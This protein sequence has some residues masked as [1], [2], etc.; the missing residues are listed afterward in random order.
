MPDSQRAFALYSAIGNKQGCGG[1]ISDLIAMELNSLGIALRYLGANAQALA[2]FRESLTVTS[3]IGFTLLMPYC[4]ASLAGIAVEQGCL[5]SAV[6]LCSATD[7]LCTRHGIRLQPRYQVIYL[8]D[9]ATL[10]AQL[11]KDAFAAAWADGQTIVLAA[12]IVFSRLSRFVLL[13]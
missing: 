8:R 9:V 1:C 2:C 3:A 7:Q 4:L 12:A 5:E 6:Q 10:R 13:D 11:A